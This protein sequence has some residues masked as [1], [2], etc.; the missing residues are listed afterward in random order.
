VADVNAN[1]GIHIDTSQSLAEIKN[2]Q[3]QLAQLYTSINKGSAAAAAAQKGLATNLM[4]TINAGGKFYAQ[5]GT[6]RTSTESFTH[7]LEKNKLTMREYF[8]YAGGATRTFGRLFKS[9]Y[10]TIGKVA[11]ER[12]KRMQTQYIKLG[13]DASGAMRAISITPTALNMKEY[14]NQVAVASQ[15]Q[16]I[17]NQL[18]RQGSTN[19]LNFG[20]NTQWAGR[21][22]M[23]GFTIPLAYF[24]TAAAKT[25]MDLEAQALKFRR[26]YGDMFT[27][28][29]ET[30]KALAEIEALAKQFTK[31][32]VAVSKTME[33]AAS[34]AAMG[35]TGAELTAQVAEATR[36]AVLGN[37][38]QEQA[39]TTTIS[40]TDAFGLSAEELT[41]K[42]NFL[43]AVE[44]QT[45]TA[46]EDLT[47]AIPKA[48]PVVKQ[49][50]GSVEDLAF[51][52]TAM[53][54]GGINA[55]EGAN[56]LKSGLA[57]LINPTDKAA[58]MLADMGINIKGIVESNVGNLK[59]TVIDFA[60]AL[61]TLAPLQRSRAIEQLFGK[62][63]F[64]RLSTL[65]ENV[66]KEGGQ[67]ARVLD[68][69]GKSVEELAILS[70]RELGAIEDA[71]GTNFRESV[72]QL[73]LAIAPIGKEFLKAITPVIKFFGELFEKFNNLSD[74]SKKFIVILTAVVGLL[75]PTLLM[76]IGLLMNGLA[77]IIKLFGL[78]RQGFLKLTGNS[79]NLAQQTQYL[80]SEQMEAAVVAASLNQAHTKLTQQFT[81]EASAVN[82]LRNAYVQATAAA[83]RFAAAN[84][85]MMVPGAGKIPKK[86]NYG[87][88][89]VPG[90]AKGT[91]TVPAM[92]TPGEAV[93]PEPI[94]QDDRFKPLVEALVT[95][96]IAKYETGTTG[97]SKKDPFS[98]SNL[99]LIKSDIPLLNEGQKGVMYFDFDGTLANTTKAIEE[100]KV[101]NNITGPT[102][103]STYR[104]FNKAVMRGEVKEIQGIRSN[105]TRL[106]LARK[107]GYDI[108]VLTA[109]ENTPDNF[110][111][112]KKTLS[113]LGVNI[114]DSK[115]HLKPAGSGITDDKFKEKF[116]N[117]KSS[118]DVV[119]VLVDDKPENLQAARKI[120][121]VK[122]LNAENLA[123]RFGDKIF[124]ARDAKTKKAVLDWMRENVTV[125]DDGSITVKGP[126][127]TRNYSSP[128]KAV[129]TIQSYL[130][131]HPEKGFGSSMIERALSL[132]R[133][134]GTARGQES[135]VK[136]AMAKAAEF[137]PFTE[138]LTDK[139]G[140]PILNSK[141]YAQYVYKER[142]AIKEA[143]NSA[144]LT[145]SDAEMKRLLTPHASH[146][147]AEE[148]IDEY[149]NK[150]KVWRPENIGRDAGYINSYLNDRVKTLLPDIKKLPDNALETLGI[151]RKDIDKFERGMH[152]KTASMA[153][154]LMGIAQYDIDTYKP[155]VR[156][157]A[158]NAGL[159]E[160]FALGSY[161]KGVP[162][163]RKLLPKIEIAGK[164]LKEI[165]KD[166][167]TKVAI[168]AGQEV[169][170]KTTGAIIPT[171]AFP[172]TPE[173]RSKL[174]PGQRINHPYARY[175]GPKSFIPKVG[176]VA[177]DGVD[178]TR[179][180][181][182]EQTASGLLVP[183][184][185]LKDALNK[186][187]QSQIAM[188]A[189]TAG[190]VAENEK[191]MR[192]QQQNTAATDTDTKAKMTNTQKMQA[193]V[194]ALTGLTMAASFV[195]GSIGEVAQKLM[196]MVFAIQGITMFA[197]IA[198]TKMGGLT[199]A[200]AAVTIAVMKLRGEFDK[201]RQEEITR[202]K[203]TGT[204]TEAIQ[205]LATFAGKVSAGEIMDRRRRDLNKLV[206]SAPGK[207]TFGESF[208]QSEQG[209]NTVNAF[210]KQISQNK[211]QLAGSVQD[212]TAQLS[213]AVVAGALS[214]EQARSVA[215][216][217]ADQLGNMSLGVQVSA[218]LNELIGPNGENI[219]ESP[220]NVATKLTAQSRENVALSAKG[221]SQ[222]N[223]L[224]PKTKIGTVGSV[225]AGAGYGAAYGATLG[226][227]VPV[228]GTG[229][230]AVIG[231]VV[232][233]GAAY[234]AQK[235][236]SK[237]FA[238]RSGA[239][240]ATIGNAM[241]QQK[242]LQ[243][244]LDVY[245]TKKIAEANAENN[246]AKAKEL[247]L[248]YDKE[249]NSLSAEGAKLNNQVLNIY[250]NAGSAQEAILNGVK[251]QIKLQYK[252]S[253]E[254]MFVGAADDLLKTARK[255]GG[256]TSEQE[257]LINFKMYS[258]EI[259]P[260][261]ITTLFSMFEGKQ[262]ESQAAVNVITK[263]GGAMAGEMTGVLGLL[264]DK[265]GKPNT[266][267]Q[268]RFILAMEAA[269]SS[270]E[271]K[272][273]LDFTREVG[274][275]GGIIDADFHI[276][277]F[278]DNPQ[279]AEELKK[280]IGDVDATK[281]I[282]VDLAYKINP[283]LKD[284]PNEVN[285]AFDE[286][287]FE[288]LKDE[289]TQKVYTKTVS[290][291]AKIN[292]NTIVEG[293][294]FKKWLEESGN[295]SGY[296]KEKQS[297]GW[298]VN[299]YIKAQ[300]FKATQAGAVDKTPKTPSDTFGNVGKKR[301]TTLD[302]VLKRLKFTA[303]A[304]IKEQGG[305]AELLKI[306][307]GKGIT[308]FKGI[309]QQLLTGS[310]GK[311]KGVFNREFISMLE[312]MD[313]Q[314]RD[315]FIKISKNGKVI[316]K[317]AGKALNKA[318]N[319]QTIR[320]FSVAQTQSV[321]D[322]KAQ[323]A[324]LLKLK[325]AGVDSATALE[326]VSDANLAVAISSKDI[327]S[328]EL[329]KMA[330]DAKDAKKA[331]E[332][333]NLELLISAEA[334]NKEMKELQKTANVLSALKKL[335]PT[336]SNDVL[337]KVVQ[338]PELMTQLYN[339][340]FNNANKNVEAV[341][342][343]L[344]NA[345]KERIAN[346]KVNVNI[347]P[348]AAI[349]NALQGKASA[350][351]GVLQAY[352]D[353]T[354]KVVQGKYSTELATAKGKVSS[355]TADI[356][357]AKKGEKYL[358]DQEKVKKT[359]TDIAGYNKQ[360]S[361][362]R[363]STDRIDAEIN[364]Y[365]KS[366]QAIQ[367]S[368]SDQYDKQID[369]LKTEIDD[370]RRDIEISFDR[371][372][373]AL[374][375]KISDIEQQ[376]EEK[377]GRKIEDLQEALS[378]IE[379]EIE[380]QFGRP[381]EKLQR[382]SSGLSDEL[383]YIDNISQSIN[384]K[385]DTQQKALEQIKTINQGIADAERQ[386]L[387]IAQAITS[388]DIAAAAR[389][390][391]EARAQAAARSQESAG[392]VLDAARQAELAGVKS[393]K[394]RTRKEIEDRQKA[395]D[396]Q[397]KE[398]E[399]AR[400]AYEIE[401][402]VLGIKDKIYILEEQRKD[403]LLAIRPIQDEILK[404]EK[405]RDSALIPILQKE[406]EILKLE[407]DRAAAFAIRQS[408]IDEFERKI[409]DAEKRKAEKDA[410]IAELQNKINEA[411]ADAKYQ[412]AVDDLEKA[413]ADIDKLQ[414]E[415]DA[416]NDALAKLEEKIAKEAEGATKRAT[417]ALAKAELALA[418]AFVDA[419]GK[420]GELE[421][422]IHDAENA[423][424]ETAAAIATMFA[425]ATGQK[426]TSTSKDDYGFK[427]YAGRDSVSL[428]NEQYA[429]SAN[430]KSSGSANN[431][432]SGSPIQQLAQS[433]KSAKEPAEAVA[434]AQEFFAKATATSE[435]LQ[436]SITD[437][438][439]KQSVDL[440]KIVISIVK[441]AEQSGLL[442]SA[443]EAITQFIKDQVTP[444][445]Q[446]ATNTK[447]MLDSLVAAI[448][449]V[450]TIAGIFNSIL[451]TANA[452]YQ[453][454]LSW[455]TTVT[456]V[457]NVIENV[458]RN[459]T[460]YITQI[461][462]SVI[463]DSSNEV[464]GGGLNK[465]Y[466]GK[467]KGYMG[468]GKVKTLYRPMGGLIPYMANGG[469]GPMGSDTVPAMLTPG[470]FVVNK[471]STKSFLPLLTALNESKYPSSLAKR[472][473]GNTGD[474]RITRSFNNPLYSLSSPL[475]QSFVQPSYNVSNVNSVS[476][477]IANN[478]SSVS[479]N[480]SSVYNYNVGISVG[481]TSV[482][483]D[484]IAR[485]VMKEIKYIDSQRV[486]SQKAM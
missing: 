368:I 410:E 257:A 112:L 133:G 252:N 41:G 184:S 268:S 177:Q 136:T 60:N 82:Q 255:S 76:T 300:G 271:A 174:P 406:G 334:S 120:R 382:E 469:F 472:L 396:A 176:A 281:D 399:N 454:I 317:D 192:A 80:N 26:V 351:I 427:S 197:D 373:Q 81:L 482:S 195:G 52:L 330:K 30:N 435:P 409:K 260:S 65:F 31:Y 369:K 347:D 96:K 459:I 456:T 168:R 75:G 333:L 355:A 143:L 476:T 232:G 292:P 64:A 147:I 464:T 57:S 235:N 361:R 51:F 48:G 23:V 449:P 316:L 262:K 331:Q 284:D 249:R 122:V 388:G 420:S 265:Q 433:L 172:L 153:R 436:K 486:R 380:V 350:A 458:T 191:A 142:G 415:L 484:S 376:V 99:P 13:R 467:I 301:D 326:M 483:P 302:P 114:E 432:S 276:K 152:P 179:G 106:R 279:F 150:I 457:H 236:A 297:K 223:R 438:L 109:R 371:P 68:L 56:A 167:L 269:P 61:D 239:T 58:G 17:L 310:V 404:L 138:L 299:E 224:V 205:G 39:L 37:V 398:I 40:L 391:Q 321:E 322:T 356:D 5:M 210:A 451:N 19:L 229:I 214:P 149:G 328:K 346:F 455:N 187:T 155:Q 131:R 343:L 305:I 209:K 121:N 227:L 352:I 270:A 74:G 400:Y 296:D 419:I 199:I 29:D 417:D 91:D 466:G 219:L 254:G 412:T 272:K 342:T 320:D 445:E 216:N 377:F 166:N 256:I 238:A 463:R 73:K 475:N 108:Q 478:N 130:Q 134:A 308:K 413:E 137:D 175:A 461:V 290:V 124:N 72:E 188:A 7:A 348:V 407:K 171:K 84:P 62:F 288:E 110:K 393:A 303:D 462:T 44:N 4:N 434:K 25:F 145:V 103:D 344:D 98:Q 200:L 90:Y 20:K 33:M 375:K 453:R 372:I 217:V 125:N 189:G 402:D 251:E 193:G 480:S 164:T 381:I 8:R 353:N 311:D 285:D 59:Q 157:V 129:K 100:W 258:K 11:E 55:S 240:I 424:A 117:S 363:L 325:A 66:T 323:N 22:L 135:W 386:R 220:L 277:Y 69:A 140:K 170:K 411:E 228:I 94:A 154:S 10:D 218:K 183:Q 245:Y 35:R 123:V 2:L 85:G 230:G 397:I 448:V 289:A 414:A 286:K 287:Y 83:A 46:I 329:R 485:A 357:K 185:Q 36:L 70:E 315:K 379:R 426:D 479:D 162:S 473:S 401:K 104:A 38:E 332:E 443:E 226:S 237:S 28:T 362:L 201:T 306:T 313:K 194:G 50:G 374:Q 173:E 225:A 208:V 273:L 169:R 77:N 429:K 263:F 126:K 9:E 107:K 307:K 378:D 422:A 198:K 24:G 105:L 358:K 244:A 67:A 246:I 207:T 45:I 477:P 49:L 261:Q 293:D 418:G 428:E 16:A 283:I 47:I 338:S 190:V 340:I 294:D 160:R 403:A 196:P 274:K 253:S 3:R 18:L 304:N 405:A 367:Q 215:M 141:G 182:Y 383:S 408:E 423:A 89:K 6:I 278:M 385:Y 128:E 394:G 211:G 87:T 345:A 102:D 474:V 390:V 1:I 465:M 127:A 259:L 21:Q 43:N 161:A 97:V 446:I 266:E 233:A 213:T 439:T 242:E 387:D 470:E 53:R 389:A 319:E 116:L 364:G 202:R 159:R 337:Q 452:I 243:D 42:I 359:Q 88:M 156:S 93:I 275:L 203:A 298:Y 14:G 349:Q 447:N 360:I 309:A 144:R 78:M 222:S 247:Q 444:S 370:A 280:I 148:Y 384:D 54:E 437:Y 282:T 146:F 139:D 416:A 118:K 312:G 206:Q 366:I 295:K 468:G 339:N 204:S 441:Q 264:A 101:K 15:K 248:Q 241:A 151:S 440:E 212:L 115:I 421:R 158:V 291:L 119:T 181:T 231:S 365:Q 63:Q 392:G 79:T 481:G 336:I 113:S 163:L 132:D 318:L 267:L 354:N 450:N 430:N 178:L 460:E 27:T 221:L 431:K 327:N 324:A 395:I 425:A 341:N 442:R 12:V 314:I 86:F 32:G 335:N 92:L 186:N 471:A 165:E 250:K 95:G 111:A 180:V 71:I 234:F 34:A